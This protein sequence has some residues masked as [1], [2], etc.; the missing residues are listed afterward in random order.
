M[1]I[2]ALLTTAAVF[3]AGKSIRTGQ[4]REAQKWFRYRVGFQGATIVALVVG[5]W[6]YGQHNIAERKSQ[7]EILKEKAKMRE[8]LWIEELERRDAEAKKRQSRLEASRKKE[9]ESKLQKSEADN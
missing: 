2:G 7:D 3:L 8:K 9:E 5:G 4:R 6:Y 1:P